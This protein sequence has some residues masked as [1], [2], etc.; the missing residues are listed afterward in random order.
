[1]SPGLFPASNAAGV[2]AGVRLDCLTHAEFVALPNGTRALYRAGVY[3]EDFWKH[4]GVWFWGEG[5]RAP[6][7]T[8]LL[9][10][11][12]SIPA[13]HTIAARPPGPP[14]PES[15]RERGRREALERIASGTSGASGS[16]VASARRAL[17]YP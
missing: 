2:Q 14:P 12:T 15:A 11:L 17:G 8:L 4:D 1:M 6:I 10:R 5:R 7:S 9:S 16:E 13:G 3:E